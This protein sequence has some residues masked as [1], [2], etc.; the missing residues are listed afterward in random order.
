MECPL[1]LATLTRANVR[2]VAALSASLGRPGPA[3][4]T[5]R[6]CGD[7]V[8]TWMI[9]ARC[10]RVWIGLTILMARRGLD[11]S[12]Q[13]PSSLCGLAPRRGADRTELTCDTPSAPCAHVAAS[14][15]C[16]EVPP[17]RRPSCLSAARARRAPRWIRAARRCEPAARGSPATGARNVNVA[18]MDE[19]GHSA[20]TAPE[21]RGLP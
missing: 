7:G 5:S 21:A 12:T 6:T 4:R 14:G 16:R 11:V 20:A 2:A 13:C 8:G 15:R 18:R 9:C 1:P 19:L 17:R 3:C 10:T